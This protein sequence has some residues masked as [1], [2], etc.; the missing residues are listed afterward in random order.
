LQ[1]INGSEI[2]SGNCGEVLNVERGRLVRETPPDTIDAIA[3]EVI[4]D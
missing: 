4:D 2:Q 3:V 1:G